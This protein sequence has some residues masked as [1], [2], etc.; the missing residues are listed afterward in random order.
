VYVHAHV[1]S[2]DSSRF[3]AVNYETLDASTVHTHTHT[4]VYTRDLS[5]TRFIYIAYNAYRIIRTGLYAHIHTHISA[6]I[7]YQLY[8]TRLYPVR[9]TSFGV[10]PSRARPAVLLLVSSVAVPRDRLCT[11]CTRSRATTSATVEG[12]EP[13]ARDRRKRVIR[14]G[15]TG[16]GGSKRLGRRT[17]VRRRG[18][19]FCRRYNQ[20]RIFGEEGPGGLRVIR[21]FLFSKHITTKIIIFR[22][23]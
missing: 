17:K 22:T 2:I 3:G 19:A 18:S 6:I 7:I 23:V 4:H 20:G 13:A 1:Q 5:P 16:E 11:R 9:I 8:L 21:F 10:R 12:I 15:K 14:A